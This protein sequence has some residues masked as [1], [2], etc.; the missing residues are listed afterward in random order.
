MFG[1]DI[2]AECSVAVSALNETLI[3]LIRV[4]LKLVIVNGLRFAYS[5]SL[6]L[7]FLFPQ[8]LFK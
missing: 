8:L 4:L 7:L 2:F 1:N 3:G 6:S 5:C